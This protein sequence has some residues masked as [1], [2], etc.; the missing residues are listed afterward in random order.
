MKKKAVVLMMLILAAIAIATALIAS[1]ACR[2]CYGTHEKFEVPT[3]VA[4]NAKDLP[5]V[6]GVDG[7]RYD[8]IDVLDGSKQ[9]LGWCLA[10]DGRIQMCQADA[11]K[12]HEMLVQFACAVR[13]LGPA[14]SGLRQTLNKKT[15]SALIVYGGDGLALAEVEA[16]KRFDRIVVLEDETGLAEVTGRIHDASNASNASKGSSTVERFDGNIKRSLQRHWPDTFDLIVIDLKDRESEKPFLSRSTCR[17]L[18]RLLAPGG[19]LSVGSMLPS[20]ADWKGGIEELFDEKCFPYSLPFTFY[21]EV[22]SGHVKMELFADWDMQDRLLKNDT[23]ETTS[24]S[25]SSGSSSSSKGN[26]TAF[27]YFDPSKPLTTYVIP[28]FAS[29]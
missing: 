15:K 22:R 17:Q 1:V 14:D 12:Y 18:T 9:E 13:D 6:Q 29:L 16:T 3:S 28:W 19:V 4:V 7:K 20:T 11:H 23:K 2:T 26:G 24:S 27:K 25:S 10:I 8:R 21:S 5:V